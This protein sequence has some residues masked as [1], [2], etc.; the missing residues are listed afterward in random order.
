MPIP[1]QGLPQDVPEEPPGA[2]D[3]TDPNE[4]DRDDPPRDDRDEDDE[5]GGRST[6]GDSI[7]GFTSWTR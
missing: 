1:G 4:A 2:D 7:L 5:V 6:T 3:E